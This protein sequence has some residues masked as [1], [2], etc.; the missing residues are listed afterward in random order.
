[1][2]ATALWGRSKD[3]FGAG[4]RFGRNIG[5]SGEDGNILDLLSQGISLC[6][7]KG[8]PHKWIG[9]LTDITERKKKEEELKQSLDKLSKAMGG[10]HTGHGPDRGDPGP[11]HCR[12]PASGRQPGPFHRPGNGDDQ[13]PGRGH[14]HGWNG[15]R[16]RKNIPTG[17]R[18]LVNP[19]S[20][21][22]SNSP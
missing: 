5:S 7:E 4:N 13:R 16:F 1:M 10:N 22:L 15:P 17:Q 14:S 2:T 8:K 19:P 21:P 3:I 20:Y 11:L 18:S 12:P 9:A 6:D